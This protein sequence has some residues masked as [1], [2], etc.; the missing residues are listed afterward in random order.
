MKEF[1][2]IVI[3]GGSGG[4]AAA[5]RAAQHGA[6]VALIEG[7]RLGGTCVNVGCVPKKVM[8]YAAHLLHALE[9]ASGYGIDARLDGFD[10]AA[11][12]QRRE[13]YIA[14][15]NDI[16]AGNLVKHGVTRIEGW[17]RFEDV[18]TVAVGEERLHASHILIATGSSPTRPDLP[19][20][21]LGDVSDDFFALAAAPRRMLVVGAGYIAV[22][23][24]CMLRAYGVAVDLAVRHERPLR[25]FDEMIQEAL[26]E[27]LDAQGIRL[28]PHAVPAALVRDAQGLALAT[29]DGRRLEGYDRVLWAVGRHAN[30]A[31]LQPERAGIALDAA[32]HVRVDEWQNTNVGG[33]YAVGDVTGRAPLTPVA[34]AAGRRLAE[35][36]F[37]GQPHRKLDY[38]NI[39]SVVFAHPPIGAVGLTEAEA[40]DRY[41][42]VQVLSTRFTPLY[43]ALP[44]R[45][46]PTRMKLV[47][48]G[49]QQQVVGCHLI[50]DAAD[51]ILQGFAVAVR[52]GAR[53]TDLQD[54]VAIHPTSAE[55]LVTLRLPAGG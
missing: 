20:A 54:T 5:Q 31:P 28:V 6:R 9:D 17:A 49:P 24:A 48:A 30:T 46:Q 12:R 45:K 55:E 47:L 11:L 36:L 19:G 21:E 43:Y 41:P 39:P 33:I 18:T 3:G 2:L 34:I 50:G 4:L 52:L 25:H 15:L 35:R 27:A 40:R 10:W 16:Y 51:E 14:R 53:L 32:G 42:D 7:G 26:C 29:V 23:L 13:Q 38:A 8:W 37:A 44:E 1:D 22:E